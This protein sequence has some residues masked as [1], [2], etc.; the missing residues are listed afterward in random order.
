LKS[1]SLTEPVFTRLPNQTVIDAAI[2]SDP[3]IW[4]EELLK[5]ATGNNKRRRKNFKPH[6]EMHRVAELIEDFSVLRTDPSFQKLQAALEEFR[7][8]LFL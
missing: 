4:L 2:L 3:K 7:F 8:T 1:Q 6:K 5:T